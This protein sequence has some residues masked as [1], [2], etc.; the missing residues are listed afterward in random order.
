MRDPAA[1]IEKLREELRR[2]EYLYYVLDA[3]EIT[4]ADY[5]DL[6]RRLKAL[7]DQHP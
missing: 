2:H 4:D 1:E 6:M 7:E 5:D 3:P